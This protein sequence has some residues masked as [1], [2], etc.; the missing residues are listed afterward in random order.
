VF[1]GA[2][3]ILPSS[4]ISCSYDIVWL[5]CQHLFSNK[6][7]Q[8]NLHFFPYSNALLHFPVW[9]IC[10]NC[11]VTVVYSFGCCF[12]WVRLDALV[13]I[14]HFLLRAF[15]VVCVSNKV[16]SL[17]HLQKL[18]S[19]GAENRLHVQTSLVREM[20]DVFTA[21]SHVLRLQKDTH[22]PWYCVSRA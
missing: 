21:F 20:N 18:T 13:C 3:L 17:L 6:M 11:H 10:V 5:S 14:T 1:F 9:R 7:I 8:R 16:T 19:I 22:Y 15:H 4:Q 12:V 2:G